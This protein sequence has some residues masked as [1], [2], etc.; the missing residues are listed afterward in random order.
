DGRFSTKVAD[1]NIDFRVSVLP[2]TLGEKAV[3]RILDPSQKKIDLESLGITGRN[4][5]T[6]KK[7]LS[8]SFGMILSTGPTGS[9][10]T[11]TLY[12]ILNIFN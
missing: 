3:M 11:T 8:K 4:L 9:G 12:S 1:R 7:G 5:R 6:L 10:K 2:T